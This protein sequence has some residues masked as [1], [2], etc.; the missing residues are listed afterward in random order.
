[1]V[2]RD[3]VLLVGDRHCSDVLP[4]T[5]TQPAEISG[6]IVTISNANRYLRV[7]RDIDSYP[8]VHRGGWEVGAMR[9]GA[10]GRSVGNSGS[11]VPRSWWLV[12]TNL[13]GRVLILEI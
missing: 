2:L 8:Q 1:V 7:S 5:A 13:V 11:I 12:V 10:G 3:F 6:A 9:A 4:L